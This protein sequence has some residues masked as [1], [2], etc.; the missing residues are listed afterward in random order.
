MK[1]LMV[2]KAWIAFL[3]LALCLHVG[4][5]TAVVYGTLRAPHPFRHPVAWGMVLVFVLFS[6]ADCFAIHRR[7]VDDDDGE[8]LRL[9]L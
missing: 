4:A 3:I 5:A 1:S 2:R 7:R 6:A 9:G 8:S